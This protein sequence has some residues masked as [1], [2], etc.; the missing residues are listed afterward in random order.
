MITF[1][2]KIFKLKNKEDYNECNPVKECT[3]RDIP[4]KLEENLAFLID[5]RDGVCGYGCGV[6]DG[7][8]DERIHKVECW[9]NFFEWFNTHIKWIP[10]L[11]PLKYRDWILHM[12]DEV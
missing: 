12:I 3:L 8:L 10:D 2:K 11:I 7:W 1:V 6:N 9:V 4:Y 5:M